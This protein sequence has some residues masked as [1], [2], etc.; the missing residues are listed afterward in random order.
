MANLQTRV[1]LLQRLKDEGRDAD[2]RAFYDQYWAIIVSF[3]QKRGLDH[4]GANDVLQETMVTIMQKL[5]DFEYQPE[6]GK[7]R[8]WILTIVANKARAA[9]RRNQRHRGIS[10]DDS[11]TEGG[12][13][14]I[15]QIAADNPGAADA[16]EVSWRQSLLEHALRQ[17][18]ADHRTK[19]NTI[20]IFR[21]VACEQRSPAEVAREYAMEENAIYQIRNRMMERLRK[22]VADLEQGSIPQPQETALRSPSTKA[23]GR[24]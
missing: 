9:Q 6:K 23:P 22:I 21:A 2:W 4:H 19:P 12:P 8:N 20:A 24:K 16:V 14:L 18:A 15:E 17:I 10:L 11:R 13:T 7:F 3:A 5:A 1:T